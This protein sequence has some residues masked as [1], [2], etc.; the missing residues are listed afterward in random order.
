M[1]IHANRAGSQHLLEIVKEGEWPKISRDFSRSNLSGNA[2]VGFKHVPAVQ[3]I[4]KID[5]SHHEI[6]IY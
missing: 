6:E 3:T 5:E 1:M 2:H 4:L